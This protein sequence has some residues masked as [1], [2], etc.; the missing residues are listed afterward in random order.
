MNADSVAALW[1]PEAATV[2]AAAPASAQEQQQRAAG[3]PIACCSAA[4][5]ACAQACCSKGTDLAGHADQEPWAH[6]GVVAELLLVSDALQD[7]VR[8]HVPPAT[9]SIL[10]QQVCVGLAW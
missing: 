2:A 5:E 6:A 1:R 10:Q 4:Q 3:E 8:E 7:A 9:Q